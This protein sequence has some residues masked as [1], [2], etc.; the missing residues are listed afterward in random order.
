MSLWWELEYEVSWRPRQV[1]YIRM[2]TDN[3]ALTYPNKKQA[4]C[5]PTSTGG[6][7]K[8]RRE[9]E[10]KKKEVVVVVVGGSWAG[11]RGECPCNETIFPCL[12]WSRRR[13]T[14]A[15]EAKHDAGLLP[16]D[17]ILS[18]LTLEFWRLLADSEMVRR[19]DVFQRSWNSDH[20]RLLFLFTACLIVLSHHT[21]PILVLTS[22]RKL[23]ML[24]QTSRC[25]DLQNGCTN[26]QH[27][28]TD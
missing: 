23:L 11:M 26:I 1:V 2:E 16:F 12:A 6:G 8:G 25:T 15:C 18:W 19:P 10:E 3:S 24:L 13:E 27:W 28:L 14:T 17:S 4:V 22:T 20:E 21:W 9:H 7:D 5:Y